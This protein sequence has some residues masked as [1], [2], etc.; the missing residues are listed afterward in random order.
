L[1]VQV[2]SPAL[3]NRSRQPAPQIA[4]GVWD[5]P[6]CRSTRLTRYATAETIAIQIVPTP[7]IMNAVHMLIVRS[8]GI[9]R[10]VLAPF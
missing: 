4:R 8:V 2:L 5:Y 9:R 1:E 7:D 3:R 6:L 10:R